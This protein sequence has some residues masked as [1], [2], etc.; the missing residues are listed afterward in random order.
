MGISST[1]IQTFL[2]NS[3]PETALSNWRL[4]FREMRKRGQATFAYHVRYDHPESTYS[5]RSHITLR[6]P[7]LDNFFFICS[8]TSEEEITQLPDCQRMHEAYQQTGSCPLNENCRFL[9]CDEPVV[10]YRAH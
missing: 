10:I 8:Y 5:E 3:E 9:K 4:A 6:A 1:Q 7:M 2:K